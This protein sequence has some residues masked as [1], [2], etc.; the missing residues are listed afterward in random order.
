VAAGDLTERALEASIERAYRRGAVPDASGRA[1]ELVPHSVGREQGEALRDL[2][3]AEGAERTIEVG[4]ALG[5]SAL[6]LCQAVLARGGRHVAVDPFQSESWNGAGLR[7]LRE[8]GVEGMVEVIEEE[9]QL[10]LPR[11]VSEG[12]EFDFGFVDGDHRFEGVFLD[13]Y[14]MT[15]LVKPGGLI[16]VDDTWMPAVRTAVAYVERN[17]GAKLEPDALPNGFRWR[18]RRLRT[19]VPAGTGDT[20]VLRLP[21]ER[22]E[23]RWDEFVP[24]Y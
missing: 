6:F 4:L 9:S 15:R 7:T 2:A 11:L 24:P 12:R 16:V 14:F 21:G 17:L 19:G 23:L 8:A 20:A 1:I 18:R 13:L 5:L 22:P 3:V 10:A